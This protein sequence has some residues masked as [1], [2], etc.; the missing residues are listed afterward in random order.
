MTAMVEKWGVQLRRIAEIAQTQPHAVYTVFTKGLSSQWKYHLRSTECSP[1][2][3]ATLDSIINNLLLPTLTG[4]EFT[5]DQPDRTLLSLP[6]HMGGLAIPIVSQITAEEHAASQR[7]TQPIVDMIVDSERK[8]KSSICSPRPSPLQ[9]KHLSAE[10][11]MGAVAECR[12]RT[13]RERSK[14]NMK[15]TDIAKSLKEDVSDSQKLLLEIANEKGVSSW[16]TADPSVQFSSILNKSDFRDAVC[17]RYGYPLDGLPTTCVCGSDLTVDH[18][19]TCPCGGYPLARHMKS[20]TPLQK[21]CVEYYQMLKLSRSCYHML[22]SNWLA[23][24]RIGQLM[25]EWTF[26]L[27]V[28]GRGS[29]R[30][31]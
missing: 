8:L 9:P 30:L 25:Q 7:I 13:N 22:R 15:L 28:L 21:S 24:Q 31:F 23:R 6:A 2:V 26:E 17:I 18:A 16:L 1:D 27:R 11:I 19:L 20:G 10:V 29:R 4:R 14:R 5:S 12:D 3:F